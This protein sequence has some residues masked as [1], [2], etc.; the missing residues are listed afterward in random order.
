MDRKDGY[1]FVV[2]RPTYKS[3]NIVDTLPSYENIWAR[4]PLE[5]KKTSTKRIAVG[6]APRNGLL[7]TED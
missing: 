2:P 4:V 3:C 6:I 1:D 7:L 5:I